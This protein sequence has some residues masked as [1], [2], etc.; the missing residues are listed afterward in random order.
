MS[1]CSSFSRCVLA[2]C[3]RAMHYVAV[4]STLALVSF[5]SG[6]LCIAGWRSMYKEVAGG[7]KCKEPGRGFGHRYW[8]FT[9][10]VPDW[11]CV[12]TKTRE[13]HSWSAKGLFMAWLLQY[14]IDSKF[15]VDKL[16]GLAVCT[17]LDRSS[18][19]MVCTICCYVTNTPDAP[20]SILQALHLHSASLWQGMQ[21]CLAHVYRS[22]TGSWAEQKRLDMRLSSSLLGSAT[23]LCGCVVYHFLG[24][25]GWAI[26]V[27]CDMWLAVDTQVT[28][29]LYTPNLDCLETLRVCALTACSLLL[30]IMTGTCPLCGHMHL[31]TVVDIICLIVQHPSLSVSWSTY[32]QS[33]AQGTVT[34]FIDTPNGLL[35]D[36]AQHLCRQL[37]NHQHDGDMALTDVRGL[38]WSSILTM[39]LCYV[40]T[41][42]MPAQLTALAHVAVPYMFCLHVSVCK[43][44]SDVWL[45]CFCSPEMDKSCL[46]KLHMSCNEWHSVPLDVDDFGT[47]QQHI[48]VFNLPYS[49]K[50]CSA[51]AVWIAG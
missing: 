25:C 11:V 51:A 22:R 43:A 27:Y 3:W 14:C 19:Q 16:T 8:R 17:N 38:L 6:L 28:K 18:L 48:C 44:Q 26:F 42:V 49:I 41:P 5:S 13:G 33:A 32:C 21:L 36:H 47:V 39:T 10:S 45:S 9:W 37:S 15:W 29:V 34:Q 40:Y 23:V 24:S 4:G 35:N 20:D 12:G 50:H 46:A 7:D 30:H 1:V 2:I 31:A